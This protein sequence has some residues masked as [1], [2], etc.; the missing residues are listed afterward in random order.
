MTRA[1]WAVL[2][3]GPIGL[4]M[5]HVD[6]LVDLWERDSYTFDSQYMQ[7]PSRLGGNLLDTAWFG[8]YEV[9][10]YLLSRMVFVDTN[11]G[12]VGDRNDYTVFTLVGLGHDGKLYVIDVERGK[13]T[14][15]ELLEKAETLWEKWKPHNHKR[16][17]PLTKMVIEDKQAGQ[18]LITDLKKR[19][20]SGIVV[21]P[22]P[23]GPDQNKVVRHHNCQPRIKAGEV[24]IPMQHREDGTPV[25]Q[26]TYWDGEFAAST[27]W[28]T[29][30][31]SECDAVTYEILLDKEDGYDDQYDTI[32]DA[33]DSVLINNMNNGLDWV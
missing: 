17:A 20:K 12:K 26:V 5:E 24:M 19:T 7:N 9:L 30:F 3:T 32:L 27:E 31:L 28:V 22:M 16:P 25:A 11:S 21:E 10:P 8:R 14:P 13:W 23:R 18:G 15:S 4:D 1:S 33:V 29:P 2:N 6:Q